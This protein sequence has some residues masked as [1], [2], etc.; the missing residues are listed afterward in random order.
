M[1]HKIFENKGGNIKVYDSRDNVGSCGVVT[2]LNVKG[3]VI[4]AWKLSNIDGEDFPEFY[5]IH[6]RLTKEEF[7]FDIMEAIKYGQQLAELLIRSDS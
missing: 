4:G 2:M 5:V 3:Y 7:S 1:I 6:D